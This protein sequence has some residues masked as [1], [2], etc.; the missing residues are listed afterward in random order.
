MGY[1]VH[2]TR[3]ND[4][5]ASE[6]NPISLEEWVAY[7]D[8]D[9]EMRFDTAAE[10]TVPT[11]ESLRY[12]NGG[13]AVWTAYPSHG[14][15]GNMAWFDHREGR[16]VVKDPDDEIRRK[17]YAIAV[18]LGAHV[19]GDEGEPVPSDTLSNRIS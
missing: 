7:V 2:I 3:A 19:Q 9:P 18:Q 14:V 8:S 6:S 16:I 17:M 11:G 13:L 4:W 5:T 15:G 10:A 12:E 1:E